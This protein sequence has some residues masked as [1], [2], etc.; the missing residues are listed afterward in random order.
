MADLTVAAFDPLFWLHHTNVDRVFAIWQ[1]I[2]PDQ[3]T[4]PWNTTQDDYVIPMGTTVDASTPL[5]PFHNNAQ[6]TL[7]TSNDVRSTK[8]FGYTYPEV[9]DWG[10]NSDPAVLKANVTAIVNQ[11]YNPTGSSTDSRRGVSKRATSL[12]AA[13]SA[14]FNWVIGITADK[15]LLNQTLSLHFYLSTPPA[16]SKVWSTAPSTI[17]TDSILISRPA[18]SPPPSSPQFISG[19]TFITAALL[20]LL[21]DLS[22]SSETLSF[23][24]SHLQWRATY[25]D[26]TAVSADGMHSL[27]AVNVTLMGQSITQT[28][29]LERFPLYSEW[30]V[31]GGGLLGGNG[32]S[33]L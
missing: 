14:S 19:Q 26:G 11:I 17:G 23:L 13:N 7:F 1:A 30:E 21:N 33:L 31:Y 16:D 22:P 29:E 8:S 4:V 6:G 2:Y 28:P 5:Y 27:G 24:K 10:V 20:P 18:N 3:F 32:W 12:S 9:M 25:A 15:S